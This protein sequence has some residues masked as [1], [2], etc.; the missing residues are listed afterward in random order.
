MVERPL[1]V[2]LVIETFSLGGRFELFLVPHTAPSVQIVVNIVNT[3]PT[4]S[5]V[6]NNELWLVGL[7]NQVD[8]GYMAGKTLKHL[9]TN[10]H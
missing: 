10:S 3:S 2:L 8:L 9:N 4:D 1:M 6:I 5:V 7:H